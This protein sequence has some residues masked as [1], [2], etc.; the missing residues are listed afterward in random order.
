MSIGIRVNQLRNRK[1][2]ALVKAESNNGD[3][4]KALPGPLRALPGPLR[5]SV[6]GARTQVAPWRNFLKKLTILSNLL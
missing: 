6:R 1:I 2:L 5:A 3:Q 4:E